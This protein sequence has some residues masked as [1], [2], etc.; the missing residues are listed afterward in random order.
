[1]SSSSLAQDVHFSQFNQTPQLINPG[2]TGVFNGSIRGILNYRTQWSAFG[3]AFKTYGA[4]FD[5]PITKKK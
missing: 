2:A 1:M 5:A 3:N 4:S